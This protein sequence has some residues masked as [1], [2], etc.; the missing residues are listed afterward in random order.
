M[1]NNII[2]GIVQKK[3]QKEVST[4]TG[5]AIRT[6]Y[7][8]DG[9]SYNTLDEKFGNFKE[10]DELKIGYSVNNGFNNI[11]WID[12]EG[13]ATVTEEDL[14]SPNTS[15]DKVIKKKRS[16]VEENGRRIVRQNCLT[17]ANKFLELVK[18]KISE[19]SPD[20]QLEYLFEVAKRCE[21]W[22]FREE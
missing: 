1:A 2:K 15:R 9:K 5:P 22:V 18:D 7:V 21:S 19:K 10:G 11:S 17:Q 6:S 16:Y 13:E 14:S 20:D 4:K 12:K 3:Y 8:I